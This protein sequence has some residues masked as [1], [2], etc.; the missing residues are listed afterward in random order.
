MVAV[1]VLVVISIISEHLLNCVVK[2]LLENE[3]SCGPRTIMSCAGRSRNPAASTLIFFLYIFHGEFVV[4]GWTFQSGSH[5]HS[6]HRSQ[7]FSPVCIIVHPLRT[8]VLL[9]TAQPSYPN[10]YRTIAQRIS[11]LSSCSSGIYCLPRSYKSL[12]IPFTD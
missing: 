1:L 12:S 3:S 2:K 8:E 11:R 7:V 6:L 5:T 10:K 9:R 4:K